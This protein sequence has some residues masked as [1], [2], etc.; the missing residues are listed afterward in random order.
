MIEP[1]Q[2]EDQPK[3]FDREHILLL[4][5]EQLSRL[6]Q[7]TNT[8]CSFFNFFATNT[9]CSMIEFVPNTICYRYSFFPLQIMLKQFGDGDLDLDRTIVVYRT[10]EGYLGGLPK[11]A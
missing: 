3:Q 7:H 5:K 1:K 6:E 9:V 10:P 8:I 4:V 11:T 2:T